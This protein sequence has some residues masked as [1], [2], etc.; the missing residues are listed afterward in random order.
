MIKEIIEFFFFAL[1]LFVK[2]L[3]AFALFSIPIFVL[4]GLIVSLVRAIKSWNG[5]END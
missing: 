4:T 2:I 5:K 1:F 3:V